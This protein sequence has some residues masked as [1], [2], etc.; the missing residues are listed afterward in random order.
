MKNNFHKVVFYLSNL[1][2][3]EIKPLKTLGK[4]RNAKPNH[5]KPLG[6]LTF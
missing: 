3:S 6:F 5:W 1:E 4:Q 2:I